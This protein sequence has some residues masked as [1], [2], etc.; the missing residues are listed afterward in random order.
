MKVVVDQQTCIG[1]NLCAQLYPQTFMMK[2][3][4]KAEV[5]ANV[6]FVADSATI[7]HAVD[8]CPVRAIL[9][10]DDVAA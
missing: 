8:V 4:G 3:D 2:A 9:L 6:D 5:I 10:T 7:Q 1:C